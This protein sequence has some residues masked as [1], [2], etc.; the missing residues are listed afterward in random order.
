MF[1]VKFGQDLP[2]IVFTY[3]IWAALPVYPEESWMFVVKLGRDLSLIAFTCG[4]WA[5][6]S[7]YPEESWMFVVET[8]LAINCVQMWNLGSASGVT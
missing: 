7:A 5:A 2:L 6:T 4:I 1:V 8:R 3:G